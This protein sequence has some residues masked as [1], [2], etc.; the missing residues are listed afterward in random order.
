LNM[1]SGINLGSWR[2]R[3]YSTFNAVNSNGSYHSAST[4]LQRDIA[5]LRSQIMI[6]DTWTANDLFDSS[7]VRGVRLYT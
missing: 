6:G 1:R 5:S 3:N 4:Y 2:L 7:Q